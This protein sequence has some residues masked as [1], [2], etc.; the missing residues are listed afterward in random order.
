M[1]RGVDGRSLFELA[2]GPFAKINRR[3]PAAANFMTEPPGAESS[4]G[5]HIGIGP[6]G[7]DLDGGSSHKV[8]RLFAR[9]E[10][11]HDF[12]LG[13]HRRW[14]IPGQAMHRAHR[15][16]RREWRKIPPVRAPIAPASFGLEL[17]E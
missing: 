12:R 16:E 7:C 10:Q 11:R 4:G 17:A 5:D 8:L 15:G 14:R 2:V 1:G 9:T 6:T 13:A 3:H